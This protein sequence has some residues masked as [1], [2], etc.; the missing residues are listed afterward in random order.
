[1]RFFTV[2]GFFWISESNLGNAT[3]ERGE[4]IIS[5]VVTTCCSLILLLFSYFQSQRQLERVPFIGICR[6][7]YVPSQ[8]RQ[9]C[10]LQIFNC[11]EEQISHCFATFSS[12]V[13]FTHVCMLLGEIVIILMQRVLLLTVHIIGDFV[14]SRS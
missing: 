1:M 10:L 11:S 5:F 12:G 7:S 14:A 6:Q 2:F 8:V 9:I 13:H 3:V 4:Y